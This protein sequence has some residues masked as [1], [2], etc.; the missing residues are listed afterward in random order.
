MRNFIQEIRDGLG[1]CL[2]YVLAII[3]FTVVYFLGLTIWL[4][5]GILGLMVS[6]IYKK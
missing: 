4:F 2:L 5:G 3:F 1:D 6:I